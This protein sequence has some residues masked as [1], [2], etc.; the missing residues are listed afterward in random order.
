MPHPTVADEP[1][2]IKICRYLKA[3]AVQ[4]LTIWGLDPRPLV[5]ATASDAGG[6]GGAKRGGAPGARLALAADA[7]IRKNVRVR[8]SLLSWRSQ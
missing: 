6:P 7:G 8:V 1:M 2:L 4:R 5:S 3:T